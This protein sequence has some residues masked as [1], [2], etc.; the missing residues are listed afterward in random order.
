M[1][2]HDVKDFL[3]K[4]RNSKI[5]ESIF[6]YKLCYDLKMAGVFYKSHLKVYEQEVDNEGCDIILEDGTDFSRKIQLKSTFETTTGTWKIH[7]SI[8]K[9]AFNQMEDYQFDSIL[10][11]STPG[12]VILIEAILDSTSKIDKDLNSISFAYS[13]TDINIISLISLGI[14]D[15]KVRS[16]EHAKAVLNKL[17]TLDGE[18]F[19]TIRRGLFVKVNN[20]FSL[21]NVMG[22]CQQVD[23]IF[24]VNKYIRNQFNKA[25]FF[26]DEI[27]DYNAYE[28]SEQVFEDWHQKWLLSNKAHF[29]QLQESWKAISSSSELYKN[30]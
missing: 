30:W 15:R 12:G 1:N 7:K 28:T 22:F 13:Y 19:V 8:L 4:D 25:K 16:I 23:F 14:I 29:S 18:N 26:R 21:I 10:C 20:S 2:R 5:R 11:P 3:N 24:N 27:P 6:K 9:P 17:R